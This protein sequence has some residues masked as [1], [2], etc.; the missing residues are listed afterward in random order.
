MTEYT[1]IPFSAPDTRILLH[2]SDVATANTAH[3]TI[4]RLEHDVI[5]SPQWRADDSSQQ[6]HLVAA[7]IAAMIQHAHPGALST[8]RPTVLG[9]VAMEGGSIRVTVVPTTRPDTVTYSLAFE[10]EGRDM[11]GGPRWN[12]QKFPIIGHRDRDSGQWTAC[13]DRINPDIL[14][15]CLFPDY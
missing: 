11:A 4:E 14:I 9:V 3:V 12:L 5:G 8:E 1:L 15:M 2:P 10:R 13:S 6:S 7:Y